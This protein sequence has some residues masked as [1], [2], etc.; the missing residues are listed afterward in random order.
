MSMLRNIKLTLEYD[1]TDFNGW[2]IQSSRERTIQGEIE[3]ALK[4]IFKK[5]IRLIGSGRTDAGVHAAGQVATFKIDHP[6]PTEK[7]VA[8]LNANLPVDITILKA[9]ECPQNFH[10][11]FSAKRKTYRYTILARR[12]R[13]SLNN[14]FC[15]HVTYPVKV[16]L[17]KK[18]AASLIGKKDFRSFMATDPLVRDNP[19]PK[20][21]VRTIYEIKIKKARDFICIE[22]TANGFLYKMVRN[23]V[24]T[25]LEVATGQLPEGSVKKILKQKSRIA[26]G[27]TAPAHGLMLMKVD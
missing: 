21:T 13:T 22:I 27:V 7:I 20:D 19:I 12:A 9:E 5:D 2:Q 3:K 6:L 23:I 17:L 25:L 11:Q 26:A 8:A 4:I 16:A 15:Y 14:K 10:A 18:E 1:G 24:G